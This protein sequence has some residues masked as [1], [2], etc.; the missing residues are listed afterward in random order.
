MTWH[1]TFFIHLSS[2]IDF[3]QHYVQW[4]YQCTCHAPFKMTKVLFNIFNIYLIT[5]N[6]YMLKV[7]CHVTV[8]NKFVH[9][10]F[11][12]NI[13]LLLHFGLSVL[14]YNFPVLIILYSNSRRA[15]YY[16]TTLVRWFPTLCPLEFYINLYKYIWYI[17]H[18]ILGKL[19]EN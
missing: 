18:M 14:K 7:E 8:L 16:S 10:I 15:V 9:V 19:A 2:E 17:Y 6:I 4:W 5:F 3:Q 11:G 13:F 1:K 12:N